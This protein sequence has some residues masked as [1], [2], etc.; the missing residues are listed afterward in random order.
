MACLAAA[1]VRSSQNYVYSGV[2]QLSCPS[3]SCSAFTQCDA[4]SVRVGA[5]CVPAGA[6]GA[7]AIGQV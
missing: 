4:V 3:A 6:P 5:Q 2:Q 7:C 1:S